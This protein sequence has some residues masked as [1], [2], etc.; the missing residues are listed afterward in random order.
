MRVYR[1]IYVVDDLSILKLI[2]IV[3]K[4]AIV[5]LISTR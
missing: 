4:C 5:Q 1:H 2:S 3:N